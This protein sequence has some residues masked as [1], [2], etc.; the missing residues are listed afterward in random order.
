MKNGKYNTINW[1][2]LANVLH[3]RATRLFI[4]SILLLDSY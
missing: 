1:L 3:S 2:L 4:S